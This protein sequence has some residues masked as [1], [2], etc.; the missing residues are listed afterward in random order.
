MC[1][2]DARTNGI[3]ECSTTACGFVFSVRGGSI[4]NR[5]GSPVLDLKVGQSLNFRVCPLH[6]G[7]WNAR[8]SWFRDLE[9]ISVCVQCADGFM[10]VQRYDSANDRRLFERAVANLECLHG[11]PR[12]IFLA[13]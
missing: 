10:L 5:F 4:G 11:L 13:A 7:M 8:L 3:N 1:R 2:L 9:A 12:M 6:I